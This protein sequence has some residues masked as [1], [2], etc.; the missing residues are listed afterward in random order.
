VGAI[1]ALIL[2]LVH[3]KFLAQFSAFCVVSIALLLFL[4]PLIK[5]VIKERIPQTK[6]MEESYIGN[7][8]VM[9]EDITKNNLVKYKGVY[10]TMVAN[11]QEG[12]IHKGDTVKVSGIE[13]N[14]LIIEKYYYNK[15]I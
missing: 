4:Y 6:T 11:G 9:K 14:K 12:E 8:F 13:G 3:V 1:V 10:W 15:T 5:K 2:A 7:C